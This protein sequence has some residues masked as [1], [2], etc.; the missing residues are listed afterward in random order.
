M[1]SEIAILLG[2]PGKIWAGISLY[3]KTTKPILDHQAGMIETESAK[4]RSEGHSDV[5]AGVQAA[6]VLSLIDGNPRTVIQM[7]GGCKKCGI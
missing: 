6:D 7:G 2:V 5:C 4:H 3:F 1:S